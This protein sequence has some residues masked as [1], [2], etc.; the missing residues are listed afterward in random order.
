MADR[1]FKRLKGTLENEVCVL[2]GSVNIHSDSS[3]LTTGRFLGGTFA[4]PSGTGVYTLT[5]ADKYNAILA[6]HVQV[7]RSSAADYAVSVT[8]AVASTGIITLQHLTAGSA[9]DPT[10]CTYYVTV[11]LRNSVVAP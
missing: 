1:N 5:L 11:F 9:A 4:K 2:T 7:L 3:V 10:S 8:S 6:V